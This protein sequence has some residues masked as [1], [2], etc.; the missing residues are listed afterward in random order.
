GAGPRQRVSDLEITKTVD[1]AEARTG[2]RLTYSLKVRN[3]GP[4]AAGDV[5]VTDTASVALEVESVRATQGSCRVARPTT[6]TLGK[7]AVGASATV[8]VA[9]HVQRPGTE[10]NVAVAT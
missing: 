9:A 6:C 1:D 8:A 2:Q 5:R 10:H 7:L 3:L 4:A